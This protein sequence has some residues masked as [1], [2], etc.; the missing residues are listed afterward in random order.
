MSLFHHTHCSASLAAVTLLLG[1]GDSLLLTGQLGVSATRGAVRR[2]RQQ[3]A[4]PS[5]AA[6]LSRPWVAGATIGF[7]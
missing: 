6:V 4:V 1:T 5:P 7:T 3:V 2:P